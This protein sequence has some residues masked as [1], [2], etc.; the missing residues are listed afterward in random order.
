MDYYLLFEQDNKLHCY[1]VYQVNEVIFSKQ[2]VVLTLRSESTYLALLSSLMIFSAPSSSM[3]CRSMNHG[4][5]SPRT[6]SGI[7]DSLLVTLFIITHVL[8]E[9]N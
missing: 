1:I 6:S 4:A 8:Q 5:I 9:Q 7:F 3:A 2:I